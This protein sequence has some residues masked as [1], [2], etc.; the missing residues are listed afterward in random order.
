MWPSLV[1]LPTQERAEGLKEWREKTIKVYFPECLR[2]ES[3]GRKSLTAA[4]FQNHFNQFIRTIFTN[5][6]ISKRTATSFN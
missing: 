1:I 6:Y 3:S 4:L 5:L 2:E